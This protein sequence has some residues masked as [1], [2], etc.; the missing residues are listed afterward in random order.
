[1]LIKLAEYET[2]TLDQVE[3]RPFLGKR[4][5]EN[6]DQRGGQLRIEEPSFRN[7]HKW[8]ITSQGWI[9][10]I[11]LTADF[12]LYLLPKVPLHNL[13]RMLEY[14]YHL[15]SFHL[16]E[17]LVGLS[18]LDD[19]YERLAH[20]LAQRVIQRAK[21]GLYRAYLPQ[22]KTLP[23]VRGRLQQNWP[24]PWQTAV[25]CHYSHFTADIPDNQILTFTLHQ[26]AQTHV[27]RAEVQTAVRRAYRALKGI[28]S[29]V[30]TDVVEVIGRFYSRLNQD[31][32]AMHALCHF[33]L[34]HSGPSHHQG[35]HDMIPFLVN[36]PR[37]Y[38]LFVAEWLKANL[39]SPWR[40]KAQEKLH[41]G[42]QNELQFEIDLVIEDAQG[43]TGYVLDTKYKDADKPDNADINQIIA[44]ATAKGCQEAVLIYPTQLDRPLDLFLE[45]IHIRTLT[46]SLAHDLETAGQQFL[47]DLVQV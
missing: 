17:G 24:Q 47:K 11:P 14:A 16:L 40:V 31:Y 35:D 32:Q 15:Q 46:F 36:M 41:I 30:E 26:I 6:F 44:Y 12:S 25:P 33:F 23:Y 37:L 29:V 28:V 34:E 9:G 38:E 43:Q 39:P 1:M 5:W 2:L 7:E 22:Q 13:F 42:D 45:N 20:I 4:L 27:C 19:F 18:T 21:L 8:Q 3:I 10:N